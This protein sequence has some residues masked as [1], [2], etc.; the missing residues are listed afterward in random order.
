MNQ[1]SIR[2]LPRRGS[3]ANSVV[4]GRQVGFLRIDAGRDPLEHSGS[5]ETPRQFEGVADRP[6]IGT[7]VADQASAI[8]S[9]QDGAADFGVVRRRPEFTDSA[10]DDGVLRRIDVAPYDLFELSVH[11]FR[12]SLADF[13]NDVADESLADDDFGAISKEIVAFGVTDVVEARALEEFGAFP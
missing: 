4:V 2:C 8:H 13:Q 3:A 10:R 9:E 5:N 11:G 6:A 12:K 7:T 1:S